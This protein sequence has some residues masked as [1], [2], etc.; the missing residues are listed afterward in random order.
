MKS[1]LPLLLS[2]LAFTCQSCQPTRRLLKAKP[3]A[4]CVFLREEPGLMMDAQPSTG[5]FNHT[6]RSADGNALNR[7]AA[8]TEI[9]VAPVDL[10]NLKPTGKTFARVEENRFGRPRPVAEVSE[11]LRR[12]FASAFMAPGARYRPVTRPGRHSLVL[13]TAL[14]EFTPTSPRG[15]M[16]KTAASFVFGPISAVAGPWV[17]GTIAIEA[18]LV[19]PATGRVLYQFADR[20]S[21]PMTIYSV[22]NYQTSAFAELIITQWAAQF[23]TATRTAAGG[24]IKD[25]PLLRLNPF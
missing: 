15:N 19:D 20:E 22:K 25:A 9:Y 4:Q 3:A 21:D 8:K 12:S 17:K 18:R 13:Q 11:F 14:T 1:L 2:V 5:P 10:R 23:E 16:A 6:W 7:S 24:K